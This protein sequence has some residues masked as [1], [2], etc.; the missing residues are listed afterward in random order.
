[1]SAPVPVPRASFWPDPT[2]RALLQVALGPAKEAAAR[3]QALQPLDLSEL[4]TG[5]FAALPLLY[6]RLAAVAPG[7]PQL[8]LLHG[9]YRSTWYRNQLLLDRLDR[10]LPSLRAQGV[11]A[12]VVGGAAAV[13]RWYPALGSRPVSPLELIV[14]PAAA[15]LV[16]AGCLVAGWRPAGARP[17]LLRF[18][19]E[20]SVPLV[21]HAG[22]PAS[23]AGP[24]GPER[25]YAALRER[26]GELPGSASAPLV[27]DA[28]D[29]LLRLC[30]GG[31]RTVLPP[32]CQWLFDVWHLLSSGEAPPVE[33]LLE[34]ARLFRVLEPLRATLIYLAD[35][36]QTT[37]LEEYLQPLER[38]RGNRRE[39]V[40]FRLA[41]M[42]GGRLTAAAQLAA[43][44][45][46]ASSD[47]PVS[48][49]VTGLPRH[50]Q[51]TWRTSSRSEA[52]ATG[53][54][55]TARLLR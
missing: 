3:W 18:V 17:W 26:A 42:P 13:R 15:P 49:A 50:L 27:L 7:D 36:L 38:V 44:H 47:G 45:L 41:G 54:R 16:R 39:R 24:L 35:A 43:A 53:L 19:G 48:R 2:Q 5:S 32:S 4:P 20:G 30:A 55:K 11:E 31:A 52:V 14:S 51:E 21:V 9:T 25:G 23:L 28:A 1:M 8:P 12:L 22:A 6:E 33:R 10:L 37:G 34:R 46:H 29:E 40:A